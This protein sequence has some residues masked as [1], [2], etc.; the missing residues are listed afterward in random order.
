M[1]KIKK[2]R[3]KFKDNQRVSYFLIEAIA[4]CAPCLT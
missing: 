1:K 2:K 3:K 4:L